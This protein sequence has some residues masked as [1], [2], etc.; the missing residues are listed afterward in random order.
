MGGKRT[1]G[2]V[3]K[4]WRKAGAYSSVAAT[5]RRTILAAVKQWQPGQP[6]EFE[7]L[8]DHAGILEYGGPSMAAR[9]P[10]R[11]LGDTIISELE[12]TDFGAG[13]EREWNPRS[14]GAR[15]R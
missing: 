13:L 7:N 10:M 5:R 11:I 6:V 12:K 1:G 14:A 8:A 9:A 2:Y 15:P 4:R 3:A